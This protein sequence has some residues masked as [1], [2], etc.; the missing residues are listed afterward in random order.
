MR[1]YL[2]GIPRGPSR[3]LAELPAMV[4]I[5]S[6]CLFLYMERMEFIPVLNKGKCIMFYTYMAF[7][8]ILMIHKKNICLIK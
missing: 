2:P 6:T 5:K 7:S 1:V 4:Q 3:K 8:L